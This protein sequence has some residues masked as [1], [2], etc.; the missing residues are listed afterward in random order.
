MPAPAMV[1]KNAGNGHEAETRNLCNAASG[2][3]GNGL[4]FW[5][6]DGGIGEMFA[7][8]VGCNTLLSWLVALGHTCEIC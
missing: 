7:G 5:V 3:I 4:S 6:F 1:A 8:F 2:D